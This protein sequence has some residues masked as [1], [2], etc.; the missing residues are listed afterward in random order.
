MD[1]PS[2]PCE[3]P[4]GEQFLSAILIPPD[5][6]LNQTTA[7]KITSKRSVPHAVPGV[8][9]TTVGRHLP[10][11]PDGIVLTSRKDLQATVCI[12]ADYVRFDADV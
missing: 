4:D 12:P 3:T 10:F 2:V 5:G 6:E 7:I 8:G 9:P 1:L 11:L